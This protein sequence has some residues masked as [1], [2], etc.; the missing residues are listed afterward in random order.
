M[1]E[2]RLEEEDNSDSVEDFHSINIISPSVGQGRGEDSMIDEKRDTILTKSGCVSDQNL[3]K[4]VDK[5]QTLQNNV[6][7]DL[8]DI[9]NNLSV[10]QGQCSDQLEKSL[11][12]VKTTA[13]AD[14]ER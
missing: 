13:E 12:V 5:L 7:S 4:L 1:N 14:I 9:A 10:V 11:C 8:E 3:E 2:N 6:V